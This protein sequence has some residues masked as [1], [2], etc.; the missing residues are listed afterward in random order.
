MP[1][2]R[3]PLPRR[4]VAALL[5]ASPARR[6]RL[7][8]RRRR[9]R[10]TTTETPT[11]ARSRRAD[12][13][14]RRWRRPP[15]TPTSSTR[16]RRRRSPRPTDAA[17]R[18]STPSSPTPTDATLAAAKQAW[19]DGRVALR[20]DRGLPLLRR[21][22]RQ[23]RGRA[24]GPDQRLAARRGLHR[25]R[26]GDPTAGII[27]DAAASPR[28]PPTCSSPPTRRA[29]RPTSRPAGTP[30]SS[31]SGA[32]TSA[33]T[34][35][36]PAR[37]PTTRP[38]RPPSAAATYLD[39]ARRPAGRPT[40]RR[41]ATQWDARATAPTAT[42]FLADPQPG[43]GQHPARAW[44]RCRPGE[45][46]GERIARRLRDQGPGGRA[47]LLLRQ[48]HRR[49]RSATPPASGW[50]TSADY[51]GVDGTVA[52][53]RRGRRSTPSSTRTLRRQLD[54]SV[55]A[56]IEALEAP[57]DQLILGDDDAPGRVA[58]L[59]ADRRR[60]RT[61]ATPIADAGRRRSATPISLAV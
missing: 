18:A 26:R 56:A 4:L 61:R 23:P 51:P 12:R 47:L 39:A 33:P 29:A 32:R 3:S 19:L 52:V 36:A 58:L 7:R 2:C 13:R 60:S 43:R 28:S 5:A 16:L 37:S 45:L 48:H 25:L 42:E 27:N 46:A 24:R 55:A 8:G 57:F 21:P 59:D 1:T 49:H 6:R 11:T 31:C 14:G 50:C 22:D 10:P 54:A 53:R 44:A 34:A 38:R 41:C 9:R 40:S 35:P 17:D 20:P 15:P 30:S